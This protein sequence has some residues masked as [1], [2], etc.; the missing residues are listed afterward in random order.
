M[1]RTKFRA[2]QSTQVFARRT[3]RSGPEFCV[4][5]MFT[6]NHRAY[7]D[8]LKASLDLVNLN[9]SL[10]QVPEVHCSISP[11][12]TNDITFS[13]P[14]FIKNVID[15][16]KCSILYVDADVV[17][18]E[19][20]TAIADASQK[21]V[22]L[23]IYNWLADKTTY[24]YAPVTMM[25]DGIEEKDRFYKL[26]NAMHLFDMNQLSCSG[27]VQYYCN[28]NRA[29]NLLASW[30]D[31]TSQYAN[32]ADDQ[33]LDYAFNF[34]TNDLGVVANWLD[35]AYCRYPWWIY[36]RPIIDHPQFPSTDNLRN[37]FERTGK[38]R[39]RLEQ[40]QTIS[41]QPPFPN[42]ALIDV[43]KK[44][45]LQRSSGYWMVTPINRQLWP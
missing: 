41:S 26:S 15:E 25:Y 11:N 12:G 17:V 2:L 8:R 28:S 29:T 14:N 27:A 10:Y 1:D 44:Q 9:Y 43:K 22:D 23:A 4:A 19:F 42:D 37:L 40:C 3:D 21:G 45:L 18:R 32:V 24:A 16:L 13:K 30:L 6:E 36:V 39:F 35:K 38:Q 5:A 34:C 20:P 33:L 31:A 7:A